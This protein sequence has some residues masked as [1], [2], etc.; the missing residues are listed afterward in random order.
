MSFTVLR[1]VRLAQK[2]GML[3]AGWFHL[4]MWTT[5]MTMSMGQ[6]PFFRRVSAVAAQN[7]NLRCKRNLLWSDSWCFLT[8][9]G[10]SGRFISQCLVS[11]HESK[12]IC[13]FWRVKWNLYSLLLCPNVNLR[14][15]DS[16]QFVTTWSVFAILA[17]AFAWQGK[18][19]YKLGSDELLQLQSKMETFVS[20]EK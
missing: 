18:N 7:L 14:P 8:H 11:G 10:P 13:H 4:L 3:Q 15:L 12:T 6:L 17:K 2:T 16:L 20:G 5:T 1:Q 19:F 9:F